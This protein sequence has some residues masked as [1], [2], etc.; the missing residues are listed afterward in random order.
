MNGPFSEDSAEVRAYLA[1][2][3]NSSDDVIVSKNLDGVITSWNRTAEKLFGYTPEEAIGKHIGLIIPPE[4]MEE[5]YEI[6]DK[7]RAGETIDHFETVRRARDGRLV[8]VSLTVSPIRD[9][10]GKIIGISKVAR[11]ISDRKKSE[12]LLAQAN[13]RRDEFLANMSH[14]LRTPMNA[15]IGLSHILSLSEVLRPREQQCV[16]MLRQSA[17][18]LLVLINDLLDF[19][20]IDQGV[21][22]I[23]SVE[24][25]LNEVVSNV[26]KLMDV[27]AH[28]KGF[29][30]RLDYDPT[31]GDFYVG[32]PFRVQQVLNNL[33]GNAV[34]FTDHG[35]VTVAVR[36]E[37]NRL[38][39]GVVIEVA[40][41]G[42]GIAAEKLDLIF[43]KFTQADSSMT[44]KY[45]G[46]GL[47]LSIC[48]ALV[49]RMDG[50]V[51][52]TSTLGLGSVFTVRLPLERSLR[53]DAGLG[54]GGRD[55][56]PDR[57]PD[58]R[59]CGV[60]IVDDYEPN[61]LVVSSLLDQMG[62]S[63]DVAHTGTEALRKTLLT[64]FDIVL[65]DVQ[66]PGMDGYECTRR[67]REREQEKGLDRMPIVA[68]TAHVRAVDR[69]ACL[70]AGMTD[71]IAK[72]FLPSDLARFLG[73][74]IPARAK[75][76]AAQSNLVSV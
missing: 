38:W 32:D 4:K 41:T 62:V 55:S 45:G 10:S 64:D 25:S 6:L 29:D 14:E 16:A 13:R 53:D 27:R 33:I 75:A 39:R 66:M 30:V 70:E 24:F 22:E 18:G 2:I 69:S 5:E 34:K 48:K 12:Q 72:P 74:V 35:G 68:M 54:E 19:A 7:M 73:G 9:E 71:F 57:R 3:V 43:E 17:D 36:A 47:G 42:I 63:H 52:A 46:S 26:V 76:P 50:T 37:D 51:T 56:S 59:K 58:R 21:I 28:D 60:L 1:A 8:D 67:I 15:I 31:A 44:R 49:E 11:D 61:V 65:M 23:E 40:D 20:K